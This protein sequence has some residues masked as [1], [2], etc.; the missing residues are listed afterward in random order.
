M[1]LERNLSDEQFSAMD[2]SNLK[3]PRTPGGFKVRVIE[4]PTT[5]AKAER[6]VIRVDLGGDS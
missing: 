1:N 3:R 6:A 4:S 5:R 2:C